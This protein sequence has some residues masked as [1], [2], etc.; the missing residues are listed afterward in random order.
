MR[1]RFSVLGVIA[2]RCCSDIALRGSGPL[3]RSFALRRRVS[4]LGRSG[5]S[6][7]CERSL[8]C[9]VALRGC[10]R[11]ALC[12]CPCGIALRGSSS[13]FSLRGAAAIVQARAG[14]A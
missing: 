5:K 12:R 1:G 9:H 3:R 6:M 13:S 4:V 7:R 2:L 11:I 14:D 8:R 10:T